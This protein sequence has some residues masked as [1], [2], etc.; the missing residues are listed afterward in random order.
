MARSKTKNSPTRYK[1]GRGNK[2]LF[3]INQRG[4]FLNGNSQKAW[5]WVFFKKNG[6]FYYDR[7][8]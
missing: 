1:P 7:F 2:K 8:G 5:V 3:V 6:F 4:F